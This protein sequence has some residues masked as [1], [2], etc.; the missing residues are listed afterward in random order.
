MI[1]LRSYSPIR[2][3]SHNV[4]LPPEES[5]ADQVDARGEGAALD[6]CGLG[7]RQIDEPGGGVAQKHSG[8]LAGGH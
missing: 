1:Q 6:G 3:L 2:R 7:A 8:V 4:S 5:I